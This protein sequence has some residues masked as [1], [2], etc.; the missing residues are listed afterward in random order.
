MD[1]TYKERQAVRR[2]DDN[3]KSCSEISA[4]SMAQMNGIGEKTI[5]GLAA[6]LAYPEKYPSTAKGDVDGHLAQTK[7]EVDENIIY[8]LNIAAALT[9]DN[10]AQFLSD[11]PQF[12]IDHNIA[13]RV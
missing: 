1:K 5:M 2:F 6:I 7:K 3:M 9:K 12:I 11:R 10:A 4:S 13:G 8:W